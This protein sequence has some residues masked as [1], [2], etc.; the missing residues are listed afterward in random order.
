MT[1]QKNPNTEFPAD[2]EELIKNIDLPDFRLAVTV[3]G[4]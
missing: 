4:R 3:L 2:L 1:L